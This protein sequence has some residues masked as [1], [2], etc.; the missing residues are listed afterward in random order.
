MT[1][2]QLPALGRSLADAGFNTHA[3]DAG[4]APGA[5]LPQLGA[6]AGGQGLALGMQAVSR[7][8]ASRVAGGR[9][10]FFSWSARGSHCWADPALDLSVFVGTE[11]SPAWALPDLQQEV[12]GLVYGSLVPTAA[13]KHVV[14]GDAE[15]GGWA[16]QLAN[17]LLMMSMLG[18][19][20]L[21]AGMPGGAAPGGGGAAAAG[22]A[23]AD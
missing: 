8:A 20:G 4:S 22:P 5:R 19:G 14:S 21:A 13:A 1:S 3:G 9:G 12:A 6:G 16:G 11:L 17:A 18:G 2:D 10:A 7:P 23:G 15:A